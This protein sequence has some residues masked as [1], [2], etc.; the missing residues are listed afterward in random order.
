MIRHSDNFRLKK[1]MPYCALFFFLGL[2]M[3]TL[4]HTTTWAMN[5]PVIN[6]VRSASL[7][8]PIHHG[9]VIDT[10]G[11]TDPNLTGY[12]V[13]IKVDTGGLFP[14]WSIY[15]AKL[16]PTRGSFINL[17]YRN[18]LNVLKKGETYC[19]RLRGVFGKE[20]GPWAS[21]CGLTL[22]VSVSLSDE[23]GDGLTEN[24]EYF[25]GTDPRDA[26]TDADGTDDGTEVADGTNPHHDLKPRLIVRTNSLNF[27]DGD[28][29]GRYPNQHQYIELENVGDELARIDSVTVAMAEMGMAFQ[30]GTYPSTL[31]HIPPYS[32][33]R[34][35]VSFLPQRRGLAE[36]IV[37]IQSDDPEPLLELGLQ[38]FGIEIPDC[39]I[40][41][42]MVDF[43][44]VDVQ[45]QG[46][47]LREVTFANRPEAGDTQ[48]LNE[49]TSWG[50]T[51]STTSQQL[52]PTI[53][54]YILE[55]GEEITI[56]IFFQHSEAGVHDSILLVE[57]AHC[58][59]QQVLIT[60][61]AV[62]EAP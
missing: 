7:E 20:A 15:S 46:V 39:H 13:H 37:S 49:T 50:F 18:G 35:P 43:G 59:T 60:A 3:G 23:D 9:L 58:G 54:G 41:P 28:P 21:K 62:G 1:T 8:G 25:A 34:I 51:L 2:M 48:P 14:P 30:L 29:F 33:L 52:A 45:D 5:P 53:R 40:E 38:G 27:G 55:P 31:S 44:E 16:Y 61:E 57:S 24:E 6:D 19:V 42:T 36:A 32:L 12:E 10:D 26:D 22:V 56:P 47:S 17:P 11:I 4:Y